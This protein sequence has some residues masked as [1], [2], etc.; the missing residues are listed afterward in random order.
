MGPTPGTVATVLVGFGHGGRV[1]HAPLIA[2]EP[3]L[4]L[5]A[6]VTRSP[7]RRAE[8]RAAHPGA[9]VTA[10]LEEALRAVPEVGLAVISTPPRT[11]APLAAAAIGRGLHVVVDKPFVVR[12]ADGERLADAAR[13]AGRLLVPFHNRRWDGDFLTV[14]SLVSSGALGRVRAFESAMESWK[15]SVT[16]PWKRDATADE[17][18][19]VLYDLGPH[20]IDQA[21]VLFGPAVPVYAELGTEREGAAAEDSLFLVLDHEGGVRSHLHAGTLVPLARPRFRVTGTA[22]GLT[23]TGSDPQEDLLAA[24]V[25]PDDLPAAVGTPGAGGGRGQLAHAGRAEPLPVGPGA[26]PFFYARLAA[27]VR[28]E[29][30][31]P[32]EAEDALAVTRIIEQVHAS[33]PAR[34]SSE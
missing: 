27:A 7:D 26:Y 15:A 5:A 1:F 4:E 25:R 29:G 21:L 3:G 16:K 28:G 22:A 12:A 34:S 18:G 33:F 30:P 14:Q 9:V 32:V 20:L 8:A 24:G 10:T 19:G 6:I 2:H 13:A 31:P 17:G 11:H 23:I